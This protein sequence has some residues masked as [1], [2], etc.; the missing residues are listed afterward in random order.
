MARINVSRFLPISIRTVDGDPVGGL[1]LPD[2]QVQ[3]FRD[4]LP[5]SDV[6]Y[7]ASGVSGSSGS[8]S[9]D[10][11]YTLYYTPESTGLDYIELYH[12]ATDT[13]FR[14]LEP[15]TDVDLND[16]IT[17]VGGGVAVTLND[18]YAPGMRLD[19][20]NPELYTVYVFNS[21]DWISGARGSRDP[22]QAVGSSGIGTDG[23]WKAGIQVITGTY[24]IV[25]M[26]NSDALTVLVLKPSLVVGT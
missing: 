21:A 16:V 17:S 18:S 22:S 10:S 25:A 13:R 3:F 15:I 23:H 4:G 1:T 14:D 9:S 2:F 20:L 7:L 24:H 19:V 11:N 5:C 6:L 8:S 12:A 26:K